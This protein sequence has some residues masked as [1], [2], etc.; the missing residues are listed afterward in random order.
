MALNP[1]VATVAIFISLYVIILINPLIIVIDLKGKHLLYQSFAL[2]AVF[3]VCHLLR[4]GGKQKDDKFWIRRKGCKPIM[5][6]LSLK[7]I[8][9][10]TIFESFYRHHITCGW[11]CPLFVKYFNISEIFDSI[12]TSYSNQFHN[13]NFSPPGCDERRGKGGE[14]EKR[15]GV[16]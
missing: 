11:N 16:T 14:I 4:V 9:F 2:E 5:M 15:W 12:L 13:Q 6:T 7:G 8:C 1:Y 3:K 10:K